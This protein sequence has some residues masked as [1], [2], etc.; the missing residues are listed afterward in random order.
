MYQYTLRFP[1]LH[2]LSALPKPRSG[3]VQRLLDL[4]LTPVGR[5]GE[6]RRD[7]LGLLDPE[8]VWDRRVCCGEEAR[9]TLDA[10]LISGLGALR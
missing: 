1:N 2:M 6:A 7:V 10:R 9:E 5:E 4:R 8:M 3:L